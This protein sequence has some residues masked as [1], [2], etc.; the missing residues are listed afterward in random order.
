MMLRLLLSRMDE[1]GHINN[2]RSGSLIPW[3]MTCSNM[4]EIDRQYDCPV[5]SPPVGMN[6]DP[7]F[8]FP[9]HSPSQ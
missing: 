2:R 6:D 3:L 8:D 9:E 1:S 7:M 5:K 4:S